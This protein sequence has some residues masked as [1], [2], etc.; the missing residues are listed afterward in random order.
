MTDYYR[1]ADL[2]ALASFYEGYG[3]V[4]AEAMAN[5]LPVIAT[6]AGAVPEVVPPEAG[7]L[8]PPGDRAALAAA[9]RRLIG[10]DALRTRCADAA[11]AWTRALPDWRR[12]LPCHCSRSM[13]LCGAS[14]PPP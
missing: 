14:A 10:D 12:A 2:F 4:Y 6:D 11:L 7:A 8:I 13:A 1:A 5:G 9:L 3:M